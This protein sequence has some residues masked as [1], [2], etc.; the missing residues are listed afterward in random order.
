MAKIWNQASF[1]ARTYKPVRERPMMIGTTSPAAHEVMSAVIDKPCDGC[2]YLQCKGALPRKPQ[3]AC[4]KA[5]VRAV[6]EAR[7]KR[8]LVD[9]VI[10]GVINVTI[11]TPQHASCAA[12][13]DYL[14]AADL[15]I[16]EGLGRCMDCHRVYTATVMAKRDIELR[17]K[18]SNRYTACAK[19][20]DVYSAE[21]IYMLGAEGLCTD[22]YNTASR[23]K[24]CAACEPLGGGRW[25]LCHACVQAMYA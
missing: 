6:L 12:C 22:C 23:P 3:G 25:K 1:K 17:A 20:H 15:V 5:Q 16:A 13:H 7:D 10:E 11:A 8:V 19:C 2:G 4:I 9:K 18:T 14:K 21:H 24:G